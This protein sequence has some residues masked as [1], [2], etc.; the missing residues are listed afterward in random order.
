MMHHVQDVDR[1]EEYNINCFW[2]TM[3]TNL[4]RTAYLEK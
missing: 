2:I 3:L 4:L 1:R